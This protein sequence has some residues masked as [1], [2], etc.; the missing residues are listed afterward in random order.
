M[1]WRSLIGGN[2]VEMTVAASSDEALDLLREQRFDCIVFEPAESDERVVKFVAAAGAL[3]PEAV[4]PLIVYSPPRIAGRNRRSLE[5]ADAENGDQ[6]SRFAGR[7]AR[8]D[9]LS[10]A[11]CA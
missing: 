11:S 8:P 7:A 6:A 4:V 3:G 1:N 2:D 5:A 10:T 9:G